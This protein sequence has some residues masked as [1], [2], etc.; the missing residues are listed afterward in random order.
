[1]DIKTL[2]ATQKARLAGERQRNRDESAA[3]GMACAGE[4]L[5]ILRANG[6]PNASLAHV[7][8][9][10][11]WSIGKPCAYPLADVRMDGVWA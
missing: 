3:H 10:Q 7:T 8:D 2:A 6:F 9:G 11:G 5:D 4:W 1:M